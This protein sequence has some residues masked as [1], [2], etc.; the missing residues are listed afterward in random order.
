MFAANLLRVCRR[1][2]A[3]IYVYLSNA[4]FS[5]LQGTIR[6]SINKLY[7]VY[8]SNY[9]YYTAN[10]GKSEVIRTY[11]HNYWN[12]LTY[13]KFIT[14]KINKVVFCFC[15]PSTS[16]NELHASIS[17]K[18]QNIL[19]ANILFLIKIVTKFNLNYNNIISNNL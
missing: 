18:V 6:Y 16:S 17:I 4:C 8:A 5:N 15:F 1:P 14:L 9:L 7:V 12:T 11:I 2:S 13:Q 3:N 10:F 19:C